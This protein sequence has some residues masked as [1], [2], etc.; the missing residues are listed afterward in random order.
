VWDNSNIVESYP[1]ITLP[2]TFSFVRDGYECTFKNAAL[3]MVLFKK[4]IHRQAD[5]FKNMIGLLQGRVYYNLL[6]WYEMLSGLPGF[7]AHKKSWDQMIGISQELDFPSNKISL[8]NSLWSLLMVARILLRVRG[9]G[10]SFFTRFR[11]AYNEFRNKD[12]SAC[13][14]DDLIG[15]YRD[16][17]RRLSEWWYLTA[18]NDFCA[19]KYYDW[20]KRLSQKWGLDQQDSLHDELLCGQA[21]VE[22]VAPVLSLLHLAGLFHSRSCYRELMQREDEH[23]IYKS[24]MDNPEY[25]ELKEAI[26]HHLERYGDRGLEE[27]KLEN[28]TF[29]DDQVG[30]IELIKVYYQQKISTVEM[31]RRE[32][33]VRAAAEMKVRQQL[34][35]PLKRLV[36]AF[37]LAQTRQAV[38]A[39]EN[40]RFARTRIYGIVRQVFQHMAEHFV[41]QDLID[42][43]GDIY[44]LTVDEVFA[45]IQG[46]AI[47]Q[48][49][50]RLIGLRKAEFTEFADCSP[51]DRLVT[52]GITYVNSLDRG[53]AAQAS[54]RIL[55]G[56]GCFSGTVRGVAKVVHDPHLANGDRGYILVARS[57]DPG[58]VFLMVSA[59][60]IVVERGS[61][62]SHTAIIGRE[63]GIPT[64]VG[65]ENACQ[66]IPDGAEVLMNGTTGEVQWR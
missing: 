53:V 24:I 43:P 35:N 20:L 41:Q 18:Y 28:Q 42:M 1:G 25:A 11:S 14:P 10:R 59:K 31:E 57:T 22:S 52:S 33:H 26:S 39:R 38:A 15:F 50:K 51:A 23:E 64:M 44:Y 2:L 16:L 58:W 60:G 21:G 19:M 5:I 4:E 3:N 17:E 6:S 49:L 30:L 63:L 62:L 29:R 40:M 8:I 32:W 36:F 27:L 13:T 7:A 34:K 61:V 12:L 47:T 46:A 9:L 56:T 54:E 66:Q 65:V 55:R 45:H 37:V 48:D